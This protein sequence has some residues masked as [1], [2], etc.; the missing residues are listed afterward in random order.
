MSLHIL[1]C[2]I[3]RDPKPQTLNP[4]LAGRT[5][6]KCLPVLL[7]DALDESSGELVSNLFASSTVETLPDEVPPLPY[8]RVISDVR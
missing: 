1:T 3:A 5:L 6:S 2:K 4:S 7:G 8:S